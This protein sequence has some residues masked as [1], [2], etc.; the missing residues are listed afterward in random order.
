MRQNLEILYDNLKPLLSVSLQGVQDQKL[1]LGRPEYYMGPEQPFLADHLYL[2]R[3]DELPRR[4]LVEQGA[5]L[6]CVGSSIYLPYYQERAGVLLTHENINP[7]RLFNLLTSIYDKYDGWEEEMNGILSSTSDIQEMINASSKIFETPMFVLNSDFHYLAKTGYL[8][9]PGSVPQ[10]SDS[11]QK[12]DTDLSLG[13]F[14]TFLELHD[15]STQVRDPMLINL[16]DT[17][18]LNVNLFDHDEYCG[19]LCIDYQERRHRGS[20][21]ILASWLARQLERALQKY[22][23][24]SFS[25]SKGIKQALRDILNGYQSS[26]SQK[27]VLDNA[28]HDTEYICI[29]I[30]FNGQLTSLPVTYLCNS[31]ENQFDHGIVISYDGAVIGLVEAMPLEELKTRL[32][33]C[34]KS[35]QF[36]IGISDSFQNLNRA[37]LY[38]L[39]ASAA[40]ENG[41]L[42]AS[43]RSFY[44]FSDYALTELLI[45]A[46]GNL[47]LE[48]Y[49]PEGLRRL[50]KH[51]EV[52]SVSY[53][54][55][56][57]MY[58]DKNMSVT[59]TTQSLYLNRSTLLERIGRIKRELGSDLKEADERLLL[60]ILL[61]AIELDK[62]LK[63]DSAP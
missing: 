31:I 28:G 5:A 58:L 38:Y 59:Q 22:A 7:F 4:V 13:K 29:K 62:R 50:M 12:E 53:V 56:L 2:V 54:D 49:Y 3:G 24:G 34:V 39:Q 43:D 47:P 8:D 21:D 9:S 10:D 46:L 20:D 35:R 36:H 14:G 48:L 57:R 17:S 33:P 61:K 25:E 23:S 51:D 27:R 6:F 55:T 63:K 18:T 30:M 26:L 1:H 52:S 40:L 11:S 19:C 42:F 15:M 60:Q 45:N 16:L 32:L 44:Q 41:M 37:R